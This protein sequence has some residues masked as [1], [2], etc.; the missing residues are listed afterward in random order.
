MNNNT[1]WNFNTTKHVHNPTNYSRS[2]SKYNSLSLGIGLFQIKFAPP[3]RGQFF[4]FKKK[5]N[6]V[7]Y[8]PKYLEFHYRFFMKWYRGHIKL[9]QNWPEFSAF[10][11]EKTVFWQLW[12]K[13]WS[14]NALYMIP[15][16][17]NKKC[18]KS[19]TNKS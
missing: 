4:F 18:W 10:F 2:I 19:N 1:R 13:I 17:V 8:L 14:S 7:E 16:I 12:Q 3:Y 9:I 11:E 6:Y 5:R 15:G